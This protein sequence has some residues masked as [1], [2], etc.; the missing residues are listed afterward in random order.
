MKQPSYHSSIR[1]LVIC[2]FS[3]ALTSA[4]SAQSLFY[5]NCGSDS[6][7]KNVYGYCDSLRLKVIIPCAYDSAYPFNNG[8]ARVIK[9]GKNGFIDTK[10]NMVIPAQFDHAPDMNGA[11]AI[12]QK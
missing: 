8:L 3:F 12:V 1:I 6:T 11:S 4:S 10:G 2:F 7:G 5:C 9:S